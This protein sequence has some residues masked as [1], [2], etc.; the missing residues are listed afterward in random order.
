MLEGV[1]MG[2]SQTVMKGNDALSR[3]VDSTRILM[4]LT[5]HQ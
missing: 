5:Y 4:S 2:K 3:N 1:R